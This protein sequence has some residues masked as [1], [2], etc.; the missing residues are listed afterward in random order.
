MPCW[1]IVHS[2]HSRRPGVSGSQSRHSAKARVPLKSLIQRIA[3][4]AL[5]DAACS[6]AAPADKLNAGCQAY[7]LGTHLRFS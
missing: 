7:R 6:L 2:R 5:A 4:V 1:R 3:S